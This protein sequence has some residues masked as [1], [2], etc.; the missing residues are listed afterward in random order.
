MKWAKGG[1]AAE[2]S[3]SLLGKTW[4][5]TITIFIRS[6]P[7]FKPFNTRP[8]RCLGQQEGRSGGQEKGRHLLGMEGPFSG[9]LG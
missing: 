5:K 2:K 1:T 8:D 9:P 6:V 7:Q 4:L 3:S